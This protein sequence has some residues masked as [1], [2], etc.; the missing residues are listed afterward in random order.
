MEILFKNREWNLNKAG[1]FKS[2]SSWLQK[3]LHGKMLL[4][5]S[6]SQKGLKLLSL[7][8]LFICSVAYCESEPF[9][10]KRGCLKHVF[11][12][13]GLHYYFEKKP[14][15][16]KGFPELSTRINNYQLPKEPK[17]SNMPMFLKTYYQFLIL[18][19]YHF[20]WSTQLGSW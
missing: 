7:N 3:K 15:I 20:Y 13:H 4:G 19:W 14:D 10:S 11:T 8:G 1:L 17:S 5:L 6:K 9:R 12:K 2:H 18:Y 16:T